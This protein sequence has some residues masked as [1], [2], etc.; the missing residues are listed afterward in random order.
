MVVHYKAFSRM[1]SKMSTFRFVFHDQLNREMTALSDLDPQHDVVVMIESR[2]AFSRVPHHK[3]KLAFWLSCMRHFADELK[4]SG[5]QVLY[6]TLDEVGEQ[7]LADVL[8]ALCLTHRPER[9]I[10][11]HPSDYEDWQTMLSLAKTAAWTMDM[12]ADNRFL[13]SKEDFTAWASGKKQLRME[14]YYREM[15]KRYQVLMD[16]DQP[17]GGKWNFDHDNRKPPVS[18]LTVPAPF[19]QEPDAITRTCCN[20]V[21]TVFPEHFGDMAPFYFA[22][23]REQA[24]AAL[25][26]F[27]AERLVDFGKYQDAMLQGQPWMYHSHI[28]FYLNVGLLLPMECIRAA[29]QAYRAQ[30]APLNAV[31]GFIRQIMGWREYVWGIY[32]LKMPDYAKCN[33]LNA[34][35]DLPAFYWD[36]KTD[37]NCL[38]QC[39]DETKRHAYAH[40]IQRLMVLGN[41][42]LIAGL[43]PDAVNQWY[44]LV[45]AD[46]YQWVELPN[47]TGMILFA[48]GGYLGSKPYAASGAYIN[49]MSDYCRGCAYDVKQKS[50]EK[51]CPFNYLYWNFLQ[52][53][54]EKFIKN[55]RMRMIYA[56]LAKMT[57]ERRQQITQDSMRFFEKLALG[58][59]V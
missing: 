53:N 9:V 6:K 43:H 47:V 22:V 26:L 51:A 24:L 58:E 18:G 1:V 57:D 40:H 15:R 38:R 33:G 10:M 35:R 37:M 5:V 56:T 42:A 48:D 41:F 23:T 46:A 45:Y 27:V 21:E 39:V 44:H 50:G 7:S 20:L 25:H 19:V 28:S 2:E 55:Q 17:E 29:E 3:K 36:A 14:F 59:K 4:Q 30:S 54:Q 34:Q 52:E 32:W 16:G 12:R 13:S 49:K 11:T 31:E 8:Q